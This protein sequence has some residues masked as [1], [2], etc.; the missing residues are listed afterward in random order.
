[1]IQL[2]IDQNHVKVYNDNAF[3]LRRMIVAKQQCN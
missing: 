2:D 3:V 1:M